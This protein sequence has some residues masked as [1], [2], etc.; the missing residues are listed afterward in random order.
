MLDDLHGANVHMSSQDEANP[1][2]FD[3]VLKVGVTQQSS[4]IAIARLAGISV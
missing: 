4:A 1:L 2:N 3:Y